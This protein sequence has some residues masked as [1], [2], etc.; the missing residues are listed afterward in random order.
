MESLHSFILQSTSHYSQ[1]RNDLLKIWA[2]FYNQKNNENDDK[3]NNNNNNNKEKVIN[4]SVD[5]NYSFPTYQ[6]AEKE[7]DRSKYVELTFSNELYDSK[8]YFN[9]EVYK[10]RIKMTI[11]SFLLDANERAKEQ[12]KKA[13][14]HVIGIGLGVWMV[15]PNQ[16]RWLLE[17][18]IHSIQTLPLSHIGFVDFSWFDTHFIP[19]EIGKF[20]QQFEEVKE[21]K[22][23][24]R[25]LFSKPNSSSS[26]VY[27]IPTQFE[28]V[29]DIT[30][31]KRNPSDN[32]PSK[33]KDYLLVASYAW[34]GN[35]YPGNEYWL[36]QLNASGDPAAACYSLIPELQ[37]PSI[38]PFLNSS[39]LKIATKTNGLISYSQY[40]ELFD[41]SL[42]LSPSGN[43]F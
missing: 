1:H 28:S 34:D 38:N 5:E 15:Y 43:K 24:W 2:K 27:S 36:S 26:S 30:F 11:D 33:Y 37:N 35:S 23:S 13:Y 21:N 31:S 17:E 7:Q 10:K 39:N 29:I 32:L 14:V 25:D 20:Q 19:R 9:I 18:Y 16:Q 12:G 3:N 41:P 42:P 6:T 40:K 22:G 8:I 4:F